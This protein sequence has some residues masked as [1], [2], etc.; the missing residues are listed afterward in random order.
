ML[1]FASLGL[2]LERITIAVRTHACRG[3]LA[4]PNVHSHA[5]IQSA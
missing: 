5:L 3:V 4:S 1:L 2:V